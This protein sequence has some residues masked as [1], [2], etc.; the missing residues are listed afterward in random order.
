MQKLPETKTHHFLQGKKGFSISVDNRIDLNSVGGF[1]NRA[2]LSNFLLKF[3]NK[4]MRERLSPLGKEI[5]AERDKQKISLRLL[6]D[7]TGI[8]RGYLSQIEL[9]NKTPGPRVL[10]RI[11]NALGIKRNALLK[12]INLLKMDFISPTPKDD[13]RRILS[14][15]SPDEKEKVL[16]YVNYLKYERETIVF[17]QS[18]KPI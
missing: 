3:W 18:K 4:Q 7:M 15:L 16:N 8:D 10:E 6:S 1:P 11:A 17:P 13:Y 14:G 12:H 9:G 2:P 5:K